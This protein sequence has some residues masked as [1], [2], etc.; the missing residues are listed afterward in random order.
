MIVALVVLT[1]SFGGGAFLILRTLNNNTSATA[2]DVEKEVKLKPIDLGDA[3]LTN[4]S[5]E[6]GNVQHFAKVQISIGV[7][8]TDEKKFTALSETITANEA[9]IR[10]ALITTIGEQTYSMLNAANGKEKLSDEVI[11]RLNTLLDTDMIY[12]VYFKEYFIQ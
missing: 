9:S 1:L 4:V 2:A 3:I 11:S 7:D 8:A 5:S 6:K 12:E 10:S